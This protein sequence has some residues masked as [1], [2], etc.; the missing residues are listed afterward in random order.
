MSDSQPLFVRLRVAAVE[1]LACNGGASK[2][3]IATRLIL[4]RSRIRP[5]GGTR[6]S[7]VTGLRGLLRDAEHRS[8]R[9]PRVALGPGRGDG[10]GHVSVCGH[11]TA[12]RVSDAPKRLGITPLRLFGLIRRSLCDLRGDA[13]TISDRSGHGH[14]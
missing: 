4:D 10:F 12:E 6:F 9:C 2:R 14:S 11:G 5:R 3:E 7:R 8:D 1:Q 13:L